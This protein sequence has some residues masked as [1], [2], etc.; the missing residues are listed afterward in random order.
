[1]SRHPFLRRTIV[2]LHVVF[3][4]IGVY[5][6]YPSLKVV[7]SPLGS[8]AHM[9]TLRMARVAV[10]CRPGSRCRPARRVALSVAGVRREIPVIAPTPPAASRSAA[11][12]APAASP[13]ASSRSSPPPVAPSP[14]APSSGFF[15]VRRR[16]VAGRWRHEAPA[17]APKRLSAS[18]GRR[19]ASQAGGR[20]G[21]GR[22]PIL[23]RHKAAPVQALRQAIVPRRTLERRLQAT[24]ASEEG[25]LRHGRRDALVEKVDRAPDSVLAAAPQWARIVL[26]RVASILRSGVGVRHQVKGHV[27]PQEEVE[28]NIASDAELP[29]V[30][31]VLRDPLSRC[32]A[33]QL[34]QPLDGLRRGESS[35]DGEAVEGGFDLGKLLHRQDLLQMA[36]P[37]LAG[38]DVHAW[39]VASS[40]LAASPAPCGPRRGRIGTSRSATAKLDMA[41][42]SVVEHLA[43]LLIQSGSDRGV[44]HDVGV[45]D[46]EDLCVGDT[47]VFEGDL[48]A[49]GDLLEPLLGGFAP[50]HLHAHEFHRL[51]GLLRRDLPICVRAGTVVE[52]D[53]ELGHELEAPSIQLPQEEV[54]VIVVDSLLR[55]DFPKALNAMQQLPS[56]HTVRYVQQSVPL[57]V[58]LA[59]LQQHRSVDFGPREQPPVPRQLHLKLE[60][61][62][63]VRHGPLA[64]V[65]AAAVQGGH[66]RVFLG[67]GLHFAGSRVG[68]QREEEPRGGLLQPHV[69]VHEEDR[70]VPKV[71]QELPRGPVGSGE[72]LP[73]RGGCNDEPLKVPLAIGHCLQH[74]GPRRGDAQLGI[75][76]AL[77]VAAGVESSRFGQARRPEAPGDAGGP[78]LVALARRLLHEL[79][80]ERHAALPDGLESG[81]AL[82]VSR[83]EG[84]LRGALRGLRQPG[85]GGCKAAVLLVVLGI[86]MPPSLARAQQR[87]DGLLGEAPGRQLH[88]PL[89]KR[90]RN[91]GL[92]QGDV[93]LGEES[94]HRCRGVDVLQGALQHLVSA[95]FPR[96]PPLLTPAPPYLPEEP[97]L[98]LRLLERREV[99][100]AGGLALAAEQRPGAPQDLLGKRIG[101]KQRWRDG[102]RRRRPLAQAHLA[103]GARAGPAQGRRRDRLS[104]HFARSKQDVRGGRRSCDGG[105]GSE[106]ARAPRPCQARN[107]YE[108]PRRRASPRYH[109]VTSAD[110]LTYI[111]SRS[112]DSGLRRKGRACVAGAGRAALPQ[113]ASHACSQ[114]MQ[115]RCMHDARTSR[116]KSRSQPQAVL[117]A[118]FAKASKKR[119]FRTGLKR[120]EEVVARSEEEERGRGC[121]AAVRACVPS[122]AKKERATQGE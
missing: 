25:S 9:L 120:K 13:V 58:G 36:M 86:G 29:V 42:L 38:L 88:W 23:G 82:L 48:L 26:R 11:F 10:R 16:R 31:E 74:G 70:E 81:V 1:M 79:L 114:G 66:G 68:L 8:D 49:V 62:K 37:C 57:E 113:L 102:P 94:L 96:A 64:R 7:T 73:S 19:A 93:L 90:L 112:A 98:L 69:L 77:D 6:G 91:H 118:C 60:P 43:V 32:D 12:P 103:T 20:K 61:L 40:R 53:L 84:S 51:R 27:G 121:G 35:A 92:C 119:G 106:S 45:V 80:Q 47:E 34:Q 5:V 65:P 3:L 76:A 50:V 104:E 109:G 78:G 59:D 30:S 108:E 99:L 111:S 122:A 110:A 15:R 28:V 52:G 116:R 46:G 41:R 22:H 75:A 21:E 56:V 87:G 83:Q 117:L 107:T 14:A 63:H 4:V 24:R 71:R 97:Q 100:G 95:H 33:A 55:L 2:I 89:V 105:L 44:G 67:R 17:A 72:S 54:E 115:D 101:A 18:A 85:D 39:L